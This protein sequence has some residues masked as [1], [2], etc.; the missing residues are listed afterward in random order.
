MKYR[1]KINDPDP[2][3]ILTPL[4]LAN[5]QFNTIR[6]KLFKLAAVVIE[7]TRRIKF[8]LPS[9]YPYQCEFEKALKN[10]STG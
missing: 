7:N 4:I 8:M 5:A 1:D 9:H 6:L 2:F 3:D 10:L